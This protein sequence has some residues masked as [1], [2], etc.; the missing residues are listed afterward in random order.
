MAT[1]NMATQQ[2]EAKV[3]LANSAHSGFRLT[4]P[5]FLGFS[6]LGQSP[7]TWNGRAFSCSYNSL[8]L[9]LLLAF[10][11]A[12]VHGR[13]TLSSCMKSVKALVYGCLV[14][15]HHNVVRATDAR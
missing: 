10:V 13:S 11:D 4:G 6:E 1:G 14:S 7:K 5:F 15:I 2:L 3:D 8:L 12:V 9:V